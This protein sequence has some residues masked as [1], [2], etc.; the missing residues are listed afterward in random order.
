VRER[1]RRDGVPG[2]A[3]R[4]PEDLLA[5]EAEA[6]E[7]ARRLTEAFSG[8]KRWPR[9]RERR[10]ARTILLRTTREEP[11]LVGDLRLIGGFVRA[12]LERSRALRVV[13]ASLLAHL[14]ALPA[15]AWLAG[16]EPAE[17]RGFRTAIETAPPLP[18]APE[19][20]PAWELVAEPESSL[21]ADGG[22]PGLS[23][24]RIEDA[25]R[26]HRFDL[27]HGALPEA[28]EVAPGGDGPTRRLLQ[29]VGSV[30]AARWER[31][32]LDEGLWLQ[33]GSL[34]R[35]LWLE[36]LLDRFVLEGERTDWL[37]RAITR[38]ETEAAGAEGE[39]GAA[40]RL[41][42][43]R[44]GDR[45]RAYGLL[46]PRAP[47]DPTVDPPF[48]PLGVAPLVDAEYGRALAVLWPPTE[49]PLSDGWKAPR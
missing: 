41:L 7:L 46:P 28:T 20:E 6:A 14:L 3:G 12:R 31:T 42:A 25:L 21:D 11:G 4:A 19:E 29:R 44:V 40:L 26:R 45:G 33:A 17:P 27:Q 30:G 9:A 49:P 43:G 13:A 1:E 48:D 32:L 22:P 34:E 2:D 24:A 15:L 16:R 8:G 39:R 5:T 38:S 18:F 23:P 37:G 10:L 35:L 47:L 36:S